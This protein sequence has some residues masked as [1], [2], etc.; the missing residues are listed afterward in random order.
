MTPERIT[1]ESALKAIE[2]ALADAARESYFTDTHKYRQ[3][4][5]KAQSIIQ[6]LPPVALSVCADCNSTIYSNRP[7]EGVPPVAPQVPAVELICPNCKHRLV[8]SSKTL[9]KILFNQDHPT[10]GQQP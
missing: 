4:L 3:G 6:S 5:E 8:T 9:M 2:A 7:I 10:Q 1:K